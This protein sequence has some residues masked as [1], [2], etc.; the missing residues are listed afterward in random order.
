MNR[1]PPSGAV[2]DPRIIG[3]WPNRKSQRDIVFKYILLLLL[4]LF[5]SIHYVWSTHNFKTVRV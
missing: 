4:L 3:I 5:L 2:S 1:L